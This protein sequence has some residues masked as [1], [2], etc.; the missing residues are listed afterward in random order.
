MKAK[1][2]WPR[3]ITMRAKENIGKNM[4]LRPQAKI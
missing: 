3:A 2:G 4:A 1:G